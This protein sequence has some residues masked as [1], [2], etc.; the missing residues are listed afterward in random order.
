MQYSL[1]HKIESII[2]V[3][4]TKVTQLE[5]NQAE[6]DRKICQMVDDMNSFSR[7]ACACWNEIHF[8]LTGRSWWPS[9]ESDDFS[10]VTSVENSRSEDSD[11][12]DVSDSEGSE[13][14][15]N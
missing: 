6:T 15:G 4:E 7:D 14:G 10:D 1:L 12:S 8:G 9:S 5:T 11:V 3:I 2:G 13:N